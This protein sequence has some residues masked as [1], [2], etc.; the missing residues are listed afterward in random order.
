MRLKPLRPTS[1]KLFV[2][3]QPRLDATNHSKMNTAPRTF[4][5]QNG[6]SPQNTFD[7]TIVT[8]PGHPDDINTYIEPNLEGLQAQLTPQKKQ[9]KM[10]TTSKKGKQNSAVISSR[11]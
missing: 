5:F 7:G 3:A 6:F 9:P 8:P 10:T 2:N 4:L 11:L 1:R